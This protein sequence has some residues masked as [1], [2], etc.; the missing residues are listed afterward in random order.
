M[1]STIA[2]RY[3][4]ALLAVAEEAGDTE[5]PFEDLTRVQQAMEKVHDLATA[6]HSPAISADTRAAIVEDLIRAL[7]LRQTVGNLLRLMAERARFKHYQGLVAIY[8]ELA[9]AVAGRL[10][11]RVSAPME[12]EPE[13]VH[14]L[15]KSLSKATSRMVQLES[16]LDPSLLGGVVAQVGSV[17]YDGSVRTQLERLRRELKEA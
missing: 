2:R 16:T 6:L 5:G 17:V 12:L 3:A 10:R 13:A 14:K 7:H 9:D 1:T 8:R 11:G 4:R 15:E